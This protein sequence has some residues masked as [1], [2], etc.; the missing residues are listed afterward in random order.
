MYKIARLPA[1]MRSMR[2]SNRSNYIRIRMVP[3]HI[4]RRRIRLWRADVYGSA[5][6]VVGWRWEEQR[7]DQSAAMSRATM[8]TVVRSNTTVQHQ[9]V[10]FILVCY[11]PRPSH[12]R[13][14]DVMWRGSTWH[15]LYQH[16][17]ITRNGF[18]AKSNVELYTAIVEHAHT[19]HLA[20]Y[21]NVTRYVCRTQPW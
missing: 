15:V 16:A 7:V 2:N 13:S 20:L 6:Y 5:D 19:P 17:G 9:C 1:E 21:G 4:V 14:A 10:G 18:G 8:R 3:C 11:T 12:E